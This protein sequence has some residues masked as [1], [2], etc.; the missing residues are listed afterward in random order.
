M[1]DR[2]TCK[3]L[4]Q[5]IYLFLCVF[6]DNATAKAEA[7]GRTTTHTHTHPLTWQHDIKSLAHRKQVNGITV[8]E[9]HTG[10]IEII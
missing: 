4:L 6:M 10:D 1:H 8:C 3:K 9:V 7:T 5:N 2:Y